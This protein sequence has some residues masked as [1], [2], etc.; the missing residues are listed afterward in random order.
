MI[1]EVIYEWNAAKAASNMR[2]HKVPFAEATSVFLDPE[3]ITFND[4][5]HS[6]EEDREITIGLSARQHVLFVSHCGRGE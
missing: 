5:D 3:A 2:R 6:E 4:P 1:T